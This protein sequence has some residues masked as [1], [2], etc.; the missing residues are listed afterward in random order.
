MNAGAGEPQRDALLDAWFPALFDADLPGEGLVRVTIF[1]E[2]FVLFRG[3]DGEPACLP[4]RC[5]HRAARLSDGRLVG[6]EVECLYHGWRF[7]RGGGC[8]DIPQLGASGSV[9]EGAHLKPVPALVVDGLVW[10]FPGSGAAPAAPESLERLDEAGV[11]TI[12]FAMDLPYGHAALIENVLD[13]AHIHIAH[14]GVRGGGQRAHAGPLRFDV[15]DRGAKGFL[16]TFLS[17]AKSGAS[18]EVTAP[19][20][21]VHFDAPYLVH[22]LTEFDTEFNLEDPNPAPRPGGGAHRF[23]GLALYALPLE[24][25]RCRLLYRAYGTEFPPEDV[26]RPRWR[27][28]LHQMHLLEQDMAVVMGQVETLRREA[29]PLRESWLPIKSSDP[30]V[31]KYAQWTDAYA[32]EVP[33]AR[34]WSKPPLGGVRDGQERAV[35][36]LDR[37]SLH[38]SQCQSCRPAHRRLNQNAMKAG[39]AACIATLL[40][41]LL[42]WPY[43]V[44]SAAL[45]ALALRNRLVARDLAESL[46]ADRLSGQSTVNGSGR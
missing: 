10:I 14:D 24:Q 12:D 39:L 41:A 25:N 28:H 18:G 33:G 32:S 43:A 13:F 44:V 22:Y 9:P 3:P 37:W 7:E 36:A 34:G 45:A 16:A 15:E 19:R 4:D 6:G 2:G 11:H 30:L 17:K 35:P 40:T 5:P 23:T 31:L 46:V 27:E 29:R 1:G 20:A 26:R 42:P 21:T 8:V 38:T